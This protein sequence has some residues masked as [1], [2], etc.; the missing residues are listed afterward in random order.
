[1]NASRKVGGENECFGKLFRF[2]AE[3]I[4]NSSA[5]RCPRTSCVADLSAQI[6]N[7]W[8]ATKAMSQ[9]TLKKFIVDKSAAAESK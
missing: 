6:Q 1:M 4:K 3:Q 7:V 9:Q 5:A 8:I 2:V